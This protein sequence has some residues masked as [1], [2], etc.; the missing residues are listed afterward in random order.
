MTATS[1]SA[2]ELVG[3]EISISADGSRLRVEGPE[4]LLTDKLLEELA[5]KKPLILR[6][7]SLGKPHSAA[8]TDCGRE[9]R[10]RRTGV[11]TRAPPNDAGDQEKGQGQLGSAHSSQKGLFEAS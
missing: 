6:L 2:H 3:P 4:D 5:A 8:W 11:G 10:Q 1:P 7:R 9:S